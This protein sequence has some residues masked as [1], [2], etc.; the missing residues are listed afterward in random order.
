MAVSS[1]QFLFP[2]A[3][4]L[5][6]VP[7]P[8]HGFFLGVEFFAVDQPHRKPG[9]SVFG[10]LAGI[11]GFYSFV[12]VIGVAAVVGTV[13]ALKNIRVV[14]H[15]LIIAQCGEGIFGEPKIVKKVV[16]VIIQRPVL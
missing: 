1:D 14:S 6:E 12:Q 3:G 15:V 16:K 4:E 10:A 13:G 11:V 8:A 7:L 9:L 2:G 5:L